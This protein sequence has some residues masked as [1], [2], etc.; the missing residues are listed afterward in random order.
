MIATVEKSKLT[1]GSAVFC[2]AVAYE[3]TAGKIKISGVQLDCE[4]EQA[5]NELADK[6]NDTVTNVELK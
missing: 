6:I 3:G 5:A 1:D 4:S 2:V